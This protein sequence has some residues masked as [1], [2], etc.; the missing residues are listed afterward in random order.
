MDPR[1]VGP[2]QWDQ[3]GLSIVSLAAFVGLGL[4]GTLA[5]VLGHAVL[6]AMAADVMVDEP[7]WLR[8]ALS[9]MGAL[10]LLGAVAALALGVIVAIEVLAA[11]FPRF[12]I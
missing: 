8:R 12:L 11:L 6:P 9:A 5:L 3:I 10:A 1:E 2:A 4:S 7:R